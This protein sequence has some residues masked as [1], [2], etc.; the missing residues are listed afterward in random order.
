MDRK[1]FHVLII[2]GILFFSSCVK[3]EGARA[4]KKS[5]RIGKN[6][7]KAAADPAN[8]SLPQENITVNFDKQR[9]PFL[10]PEEELK[11]RD[12]EGRLII[13]KPRVLA[14]FSSPGKS[15]ALIGGRVFKVG[16]IF[17][18]KEVIGISP[19]GVIL[20]DRHTQYILKMP[21]I[22]ERSP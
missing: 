21:D 9:N 11:F 13:D 7:E 10:T 6:K 3:E 14:V 22:I 8:V 16:D 12:K 15:G 1:I 18:N 2:L 5:G 19:S 20:K 17:D 4:I